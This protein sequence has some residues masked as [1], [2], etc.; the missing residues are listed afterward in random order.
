MA[1]RRKKLSWKSTFGEIVVEEPQLRKGAN[2]LRPFVSSAKVSHRGTSRPLRRVV[3]NFAADVSY[4][5][6]VD[7][8]IEHYDVP[9]DKSTIR[10]ITMRHG[11]QMLEAQPLE[12]A[13]LKFEGETQ[14]IAAMDG[15]LVPIMEP[16]PQ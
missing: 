11:Q 13:W 2:G 3:T 6:V 5:Q 16:D 9:L 7:K 15:S 10:R 14:V 8:L 12:T 1:R 4:A